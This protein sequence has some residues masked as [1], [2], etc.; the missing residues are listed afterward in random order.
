MERRKLEFQQKAWEEV[1]EKAKKETLFDKGLSD[2]LGDLANY[3]YSKDAFSNV[4]KCLSGIYRKEPNELKTLEEF[5]APELQKAVSLFVGKERLQDMIEMSGIQITGQFS[6]SMWRRSY[7]SSDVGYHAASLI[8][9]VANWLYW[10]FYGVSAEEMLTCEHDW[11]RGYKYYLALEIRRENTEVLKMLQD[12]I[13]GENQQVLL[14]RPMIQAIVISG[15]KGM[16]DLLL[17]LLVAARLQE[18]LRQSILESADEGSTETLI[19]IMKVCLKED[20][21]R[22]SSAI[23]AFDTWTGLGYGDAKAAVVKK[24]AAFAYA[25]LTD[26]KMRKQYRNSENNLEAYLAIWSMGC[27]EIADTDETVRKLLDDEMKYRRILGWFFVTHTDHAGYQMKM[28]ASYLWER[29]E[30]T[31]AWIV[32]NLALTPAL[33]SGYTYGRKEWK[34]Q[35]VEN[36]MFPRDKEKRRKLFAELKAAAEFI[37]NKNREFQGNPFDFSS[38]TLEN[39]RV[40]KCMLSVAGYDMDRAMIDELYQMLPLMDV[41]TRR[42][43]YAN[44]LCPETIMIHRQYLREA[45]ED[46]S[47]YVKEL[48]VQRLSACS[49]LEE[50]L[51]ALACSLRSKSSSL[52]KAVMSV[53]AAQPAVRLSP[54]VETLL[55]SGESSQI[56]AGIELLLSVKTEHP[57]ILKAHAE[58][59][60]KVR[61][62]K[63]S[64]QTEILLDQLEDT[65]E[66]LAEVYTEENGFGLYCPAVTEEAAALPEKAETKPRGLI[67]KLFGRPSAPEEDI[68]TLQEIKSYLPASKEYAKLMERMNSVFEKH[69]DYEYEIIRYDGSREKILFGNPAYGGIR[70]PAEFGKQ[71]FYMGAKTLRMEMVPFYQEFLEAMGEYTTNLPKMLG[72]CYTAARWQEPGSWYNLETGKWFQGLLEKGFAVT[73]HNWG[74]ENYKNRYW[75]MLD[76]IR[77]LPQEFDAHTCFKMAM[78]FQRSIIKLIGYENLGKNY[79]EE[80][81]EKKRYYSS[82][83]N[84]KYPMNHRSVGYWRIVMSSC[85]ADP[86]DFR[87][88]FLEEYR[89]EHRMLGK[90]VAKPLTLEE[91]FRAVDEKIVPKDVLYE[92]ILR[93]KTSQSDIRVLTA[94]NKFGLQ[95]KRIYDAYPWA[96]DLVNRAVLR[97]VEIEE[98]RG[99]LPTVLTDAA[100]AIER[101]E[102]AEHFC[103]LLA[104]L[105]KE[106][107]FRGYAYSQD[108]TKRAVLSLLLKRCYP[109]KEDTPERLANYLKQ[110]DIKEKRLA[111]AVMYA[112]Q[113]AEFAE[114]ILGWKGLKCAVWFFHAHINESF[115]AEKETEVAMYSP[116]TP[117]QFNDGAF[118]KDWF[119]R[120]YHALGEKRF[121]ILY[122]SA[123]YITSGGNQHRRSQLYSDAV[124]GRLDAESLKQEITEKRNQEKLRCYPLIPIPENCPEEALR[125]YEFLQKFLKE[126]KQFGAQRRESEKKAVA[127]A[128][129]NLAITTGFMDV[130]RM[131]WYLESEKLEE[132]RPLMEPQTVEGVQIWLEITE[133]GTAE[134]AVSK[135]GKRQKSLPKA[136]SK[137]EVV[138]SLKATIKELKEQKSRAK[139]SLERAMVERT[140]FGKAELAKII[141]NPVLSPMLAALVW[142]CDGK[143]GF[144]QKQGE[145]LLLCDMVGNCQPLLQEVHIAHPHDLM[146]TGEWADYMRFLYE[147]KIVQ[148]FK[149]VFREYYPITED[150]RQ[151]KNISRRYAGYQVQPKK[152]V[153]LLKTRGWTVDYEE[154]LQKVF[155]KENLIVRMYALADWFSPADIEAPTL[156]TIQFFDRDSGKTVE[157]EHVPPILFSEVMRDIDLAVSVAYVGG[158]DP[159]ASHST[160]EMR[161]AIAAELLKLL[162]ISNVEFIGSHAKIKGSLGNYSVHMGSGIVH[163]QA[164]GAVTILPVHSQAR[165]RI[166]L[167]FA[168]DDP[169][170]QEIMSKILLLA[171]DKKIKDPEILRQ[172][173]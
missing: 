72:L 69:A 84:K 171:E 128:M 48:A 113:W 120:A 139:E 76:I 154:G 121:Q 96:K 57:E 124:L 134:L 106:N 80:I 100:R 60:E 173:K 79:A 164:V 24:M 20:L 55:L 39:S 23:R 166:F 51:L 104:A 54:V 14:S 109:A 28:A 136:I 19:W 132:I 10:H 25:C 17:R 115:S 1:R 130:N 151:E 129:E 167:P 147:R 123:K 12:A 53:F 163:V 107:F 168:D 111:E 8:I 101:F 29:D 159:E 94:P 63:I 77:L 85:A 95:G 105:G 144:L 116:I 15:H 2:A 30:E 133:D 118:D 31:L 142:N 172:L 156:E 150:E 43:F 65:Q 59:L 157:F 5:W 70:I 153:A 61:E 87:E 73:Y 56:Q 67:G 35:S 16:L 117:Q 9:S 58:H 74:Y 169:K 46:K 148:P 75:Q 146:R 52:R 102:G 64:T 44:F 114:K 88:W 47:V 81:Q 33:L 161:M 93:S 82:G 45:L 62:G 11:I 34:W 66:V 140:K 32:H 4:W 37:G 42:A 78:K 50:D 110:T 49:L 152:T 3:C 127:T 137:N 83:D 158:V 149:Q 36:S 119:F 86:E 103:N 165:G 143:N 22:Y 13:L 145:E 27:Y 7:R 6:Q 71:E 160:V 90:S 91:Y 18:G 155:Y 122:K 99:E 170:T 141:D 68:F 92:K 112:P 162:K 108:S 98:K 38:I 40:I 126:S 26:E 41:D 125:R 135:A 89:Q 138:L 131:V 97:I 21:F